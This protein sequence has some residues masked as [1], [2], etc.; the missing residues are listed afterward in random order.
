MK[1][2]IKLKQCFGS[3][4]ATG[5]AGSIVEVSE[6]TAAGLISANAA[7]RVGDVV[8]S[9]SPDPPTETATSPDS[10]DVETG[11]KK[12]KRAPRSRSQGAN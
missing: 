9:A 6:G 3:A 12:S 4:E 7:E 1:V 5:S 10:A 8:E 2:Q 11:A